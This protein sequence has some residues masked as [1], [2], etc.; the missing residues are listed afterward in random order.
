MT[1]RHDTL[2][3]EIERLAAEMRSSKRR[4]RTNV[5][6]LQQMDELTELLRRQS[7]EL[8]EEAEKASDV[9]EACRDELQR[10]SQNEQA[11]ERLKALQ[12]SER[13]RQRENR[14]AA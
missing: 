9:L 12:A 10:A 5:K 7:G 1:D 11:V 4:G 3:E 2:S 14:K 8:L 13:A 6:A